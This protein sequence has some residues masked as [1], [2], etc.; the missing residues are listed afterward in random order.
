MPRVLDRS[1]RPSN[2]LNDAA[3]LAEPTRSVGMTDA[4]I[5]PSPTSVQRAPPVKAARPLRRSRAQVCGGRAHPQL[6]VACLRRRLRRDDWCCCYEVF[7]FSSAATNAFTPGTPQTRNRVGPPFSDMSSVKRRKGQHLRSFS[8][9]V[10]TV[11]GARL[12][13]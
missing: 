1:R 12:A 3:G 4:S 2:A 9:Q 8:T 5:D 13:A 11:D 6:A 10:I 7:T